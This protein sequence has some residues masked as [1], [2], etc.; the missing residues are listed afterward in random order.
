MGEAVT[1]L[2]TSVGCVVERSPEG[3]VVCQVAFRRPHGAGILAAGR[4]QEVTA[5]S[6]A[7]G[8]M[9]SPQGEGGGC[10][11]GVSVR[12]EEPSLF[13]GGDLLPGRLRGRRGPPR[14]VCGSG[15]QRM[16]RLRTWPHKGH[17]VSWSRKGSGGA[18]CS[19]VRGRSTTQ[20]KER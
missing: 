15:H 12:L 4:R 6:R 11:P 2:V 8:I 7:S 5:K 18:V 17:C 14:C 9:S 13:S 10:D 3:L 19:A 20:S 16:G 1:V